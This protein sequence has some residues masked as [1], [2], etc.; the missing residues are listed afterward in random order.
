MRATMGSGADLTDLCQ[1]LLDT[2]IRAMP[3]VDDGKVV[4]NGRTR[5]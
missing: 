5:R 4:G 1:A 2:H 3:I